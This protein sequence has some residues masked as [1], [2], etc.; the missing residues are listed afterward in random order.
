MWNEKKDLFVVGLN[1]NSQHIRKFDG[2]LLRLLFPLLFF[3]LFFFQK[4]KKEKK[5][6]TRRVGIRGGGE[7][8]DDDDEEENC[9]VIL[10]VCCFSDDEHTTRKGKKEKSIT[11]LMGREA[12]LSNFLFFFSRKKNSFQVKFKKKGKTIT[13]ESRI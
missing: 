11:F 10:N 12:W 9:R 6:T 3:F 2:C 7:G 8:G 1:I 13:G 4:K 5:Y